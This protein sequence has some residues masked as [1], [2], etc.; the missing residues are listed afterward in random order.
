MC[1]PRGAGDGAWEGIGR[2]LVEELTCVGL[3]T[4]FDSLAAVI[5]VKRPAGYSGDLCHAG[6]VEY[7]AFWADWNNDGTW[8]EYLGTTQVN[9]RV[10][11]KPSGLLDVVL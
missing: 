6:S 2:S 7:V 8:D 10:V 1:Q 11:A 3:A 9:V 4:A 5:H